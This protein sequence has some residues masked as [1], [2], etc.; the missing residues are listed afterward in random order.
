MP[1]MR[2]LKPEACTSESLAEVD[3]GVRWTFATF[4]TH[5]DDEGRAVW[6]LRLIKA[7]LYPLDD[8]MTLDVLAGDFDELERVGAVCRYVVDGR[9]Y[10]H[11]PTF[12]EHQH[13]NRPVPSKLPPCPK[14]D[15][16]PPTHAHSSEDSVSPHGALTPVV[17]GEGRVEVEGEVGGGSGN[18]AQARSTRLPDQW[19]PDDAL[20]AW[21][22]SE[23]I[24]DDLA[25]RELDRF[26]DY[27][28]G[29]GGA[30]G[31]KADWPATWRNWLRRAFTESPGPYS[32]QQRETDD[33]FNR[34]ARRMGVV[35]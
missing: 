32:R 35:Q 4:W 1:R 30:R 22:R 21:H 24:P 10:V 2:T 15:H 23:G 20:I 3:R 7:A 33:L 34:A 17:V 27:W 5:C 26:R 31:R 8:H 12:N 13:P 18:R 29:V 16:A 19:A 9:E 11:V 14:S 28:R 25:R 6:N